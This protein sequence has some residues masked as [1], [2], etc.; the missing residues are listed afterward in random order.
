ME[1]GREENRGKKK[2][3]PRNFQNAKTFYRQTLE[4]HHNHGY[5]S[6]HIERRE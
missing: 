6:F 1:K 2:I 4:L 5:Y 3:Q